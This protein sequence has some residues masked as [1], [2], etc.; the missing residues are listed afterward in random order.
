M[1]VSIDG[2]DARGEPLLRRKERLLRLMPR[3]ESRLLYLDHMPG[4]GSDL[5]RAA[6]DRDLDVAKWVHGTYHTDGRRTS[7]LK[8][9]NPAYSQIG[10]RRELFEARRDRRTRRTVGL[11][12]LPLT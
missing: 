6:C 4:R 3:P 12:K 9:K 11:P 5:F 10:G 1:F 2:E 8:V 7:W